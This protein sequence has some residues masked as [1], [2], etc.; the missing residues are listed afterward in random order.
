MIS[1]NQ[2]ARRLLCGVAAGA[3]TLP[4]V[5]DSRAETTLPAV[6]A[7]NG[8][9]DFSA[10]SQGLEAAGAIGGSY[11]FPVG[12]SFGAQIDGGVAK[13]EENQ[14]GGL[15]GHFFYRDPTAFLA[16]ASS[17]WARVNGRDVWRNGLEGELYRG[18]VTL[19]A[20]AGVQ[21]AIGRSTGYAAA[22][23]G[24][25]FTDDLLVGVGVSGY[26]A[27]RAVGANAEMRPMADSPMSLF[28]N[29]GAGNIGG[30]YA[31]VGVR[32]AIGSG[33]VSLKRQ[34]RE[35]DPAN[36]LTQFT[37]AGGNVGVSQQIEAIKSV[38]VASPVIIVCF[39]AGTLV[40][41]ADGSSKKIEDIAVDDVVLG[42]DGSSN[43]VTKLRPAVLG[44][45][46]LYAINGGTPFV[47]DSHPLMTRDGW[48]AVDPTESAQVLP[49]LEIGR[50]EPGDFLVGLDGDV[51]V[52][53]IEAA[54]GHPGMPVYN[55][56][57]TGNHTYFVAKADAPTTFIVA[58]NR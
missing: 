34:H 10:G 56:S 7:P 45:R 28:A 11:S 41:M 54:D 18:D 4:A 31:M 24:Y 22:D 13:G 57:V 35:Y 20:T 25:Y 39:V 37:S 58:H 38:P 46:K 52:R 55:F 17:M 32:F 26:S 14:S 51:E 33:N 53:S 1:R 30:G 2:F 50:L 40:R 6:A 43:R 47:T 8:K 42:M 49:E 15:A 44:E 3:L 5:V 19:S 36:I 12:H 23:A 27:Y 16:G 21:N 9:I 48:K 29:I